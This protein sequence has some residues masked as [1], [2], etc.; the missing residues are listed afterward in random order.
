MHHLCQFHKELQHIRNPFACDG[1]CGHD[2]HILSRIGVLPV[3]RHIETLQS[4]A[5][6]S[7]PWTNAVYLKQVYDIYVATKLG[8]PLPGKAVA[9]D[10][11]Q[12]HRM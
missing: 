5:K 10:S 4:F 3:Q 7:N 12:L 8:R 11:D 6:P 9:L 1:G 2:V